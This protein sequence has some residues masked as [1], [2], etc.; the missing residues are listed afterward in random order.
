MKKLAML[1]V[2]AL[3]AG[4]GAT[5]PLPGFADNIYQYEKDGKVW[6]GNFCPRGAKKCRLIMKG[7]PGSARKEAGSGSGSGAA[8]SSGGAGATRPE[9]KWKPP[10]TPAVA[11][12]GKPAPEVPAEIDGVIGKASD[13]YDIPEA[14]IRAV[15]EVES[16]YKVKALSYKGA[17]GLMQLMPGTAADM[18]VTDPWDPYQN[19]MGGTRFLRILANRFNGDMPKVLAAYHAGGG[20]VSRAEGIPYQGSDGYVRKVLDHYYKLKP[21]R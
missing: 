18:G 2:A 3:V 21:R 10:T 7:S 19:V 1:V 6:Y 12:I 4:T 17:M 14:F 15:I 13:T 16:S 9:K 8:G 11:D 20:S 5:A